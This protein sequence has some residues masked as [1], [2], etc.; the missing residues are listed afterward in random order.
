MQYEIEDIMGQRDYRSHRMLSSLLDACQDELEAMVADET[1]SERFT[2]RLRQRMD[3]LFGPSKA[4]PREI[5]PG[6]FLAALFETLR[7]NF[8][9][10]FFDL[11]TT[12]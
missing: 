9:H 11:K 7:P 1:G 2:D 4:T 5:E 10:R 3:A 12:L 8:A 6:P